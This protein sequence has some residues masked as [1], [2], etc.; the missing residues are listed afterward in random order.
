M[1]ELVE[2]E[3]RMSHILGYKLNSWT[4]FDLAMIKLSLH[5]QNQ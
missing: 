4:I 1:K 2:I 5:L 3:A